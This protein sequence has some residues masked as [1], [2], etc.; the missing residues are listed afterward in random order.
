MKQLE[1]RWLNPAPAP[2]P[3]AAAIEFDGRRV[4]V[5]FRRN[6][7]ARRYRLYLNPTGVPC[8]TIPRRGTW[9]YA[10]QFLEKHHH[11]LK[12]QLRRYATAESGS[13]EWAI[14]SEILFRGTLAR[15]EFNPDGAP[16]SLRLGSEPV[17]LPA[18]LPGGNGDW[19]R[20]VEHHLRRVATVELPPRVL[21]LA[22]QHQTPVR[23]ITIRAQRTRWGSCSESGT[24]SLNWRLVQVPVEIRDYVILHELMHLKEMNHSRRF[25]ALVAQVCPTFRTC[26]A[27]LRAHSSLLL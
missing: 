22:A 6:D 15:L 10:Q 2:A 13:A 9:R 3:E 24:V 19:R 16:A 27:W 14:G 7:R 1:L 26:K 25:W 18:N 5:L 20:V 12:Q 21:E 11:W 8:V 23:R 17:P 4:P